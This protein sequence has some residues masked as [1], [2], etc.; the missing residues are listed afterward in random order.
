MLIAMQIIKAIRVAGSRFSMSPRGIC[1]SLILRGL[2]V[3][4]TKRRSAD[5]DLNQ[6]SSPVAPEV[7]ASASELGLERAYRQHG[8]VNLRSIFD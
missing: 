1:F 4:K 7:R 2:A 8:S 5:S 3:G 6:H